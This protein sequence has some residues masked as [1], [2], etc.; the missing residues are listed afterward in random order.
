MS[1]EMVDNPRRAWLQSLLAGLDATLAQMRPVLDRPAAAFGSGKVWTGTR[2][3]SDFQAELA[4]R[5][6]S[7]H[8]LTDGLRTTVEDALRAEPLKVTADQARQME[9]DHRRGW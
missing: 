2:A 1:G 4:G 8:T 7:V 9:H 3:A 6:R 5:S